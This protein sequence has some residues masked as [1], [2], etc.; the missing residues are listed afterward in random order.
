[1]KRFGMDYFIAA[2]MCAIIM[3]VM[4]SSA[5]AGII[6]VKWN[7]PGSGD[8]PVF[9][10]QSWDTAFHK[11][12]DGINASISGDDIWV[13]AGTYVE[14]VVMKDGVALYGGFSGTE[15]SRDQRDWTANRTILDGNKQGCVI[16]IQNCPSST[17]RVDGFTIRNGTGTA[18]G[19]ANT[20]GGGIYCTSSSPVIAD[21][22]IRDNSATNGA[23]I[24][25]TASASTIRNNTIR[26]KSYSSRN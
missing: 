21:N 26:N 11:V 24:Y 25:T 20:A 6:Y 8:P 7:S 23:G 15:T 2:A 13:A 19:G 10:G 17:T 22:L 4:S 16:K 18:S 3:F 14:N 12:Q 1:M 9:D 5:A